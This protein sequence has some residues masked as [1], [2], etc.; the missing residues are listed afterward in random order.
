VARHYSL[1]ASGDLF[2]ASLGRSPFHVVREHGLLR[3]RFASSLAD[4]LAVRHPSNRGR[5]RQPR[6]GCA[7]LHALR[8]ALAWRAWHCRLRPAWAGG[9]VSRRWVRWR[10]AGRTAGTYIHAEPG[11]STQPDHRR[12]PRLERPRSRGA[13]LRHASSRR[14]SVP[15][16]RSIGLTC[17]LS[18]HL[19]RRGA[20]P[21]A[22]PSEPRAVPHRRRLELACG[23]RGTAGHEA[24]A[25]VGAPRDPRAVAL[26]GVHLEPAPRG[27]SVPQGRR[28]V[29]AGRL[30][31]CSASRPADCRG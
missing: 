18:H 1:W 30:R 5:Q 6:A 29:R 3:H 28:L 13:C 23:G 11:E 7:V 8:W 31:G 12:H 14:T 17:R 27:Y 19:V 16:G 9:V 26:E 10:V 22:L 20:S 15:G 24:E 2:P 25:V 4:P 21:A